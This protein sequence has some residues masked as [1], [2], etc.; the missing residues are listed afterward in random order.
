VGAGGKVRE[1]YGVEEDARELDFKSPLHIDHILICQLPMRALMIPN[2]K[3]P[4]KIKM[5]S[6][7]MIA[8]VHLTIRT[9]IDRK[10]ILM[11]VTTTFMQSADILVFS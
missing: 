9:T 6:A 3:N 5:T 2:V 7:G 1:P 4:I 10:G 11:S 8:T